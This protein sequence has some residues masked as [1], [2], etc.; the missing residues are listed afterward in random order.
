MKIVFLGTS[1]FAVPSLKKL[2]GTHEIT[3]VITKRDKPQGRRLVS[4]PS[5]VKA[6]AQ[7]LGLP[8]SSVEGLPADKAAESLAA[9]GADIFVVI[10][11]GQIL[12]AKVLSLPGMGSIGLHA[13]L[14]PK[15]RGP[16][17][18]NWAII[19]GETATGVTV[20][21]LNEK[22]D[23][24]AIVSQSRVE[25]LSS[26]NAQT[27]S[28]K[29][30]ATGAE[31]LC[32]SIADMASGKA[33]FT[34]QDARSATVTGKLKKEDGRIDWSRPAQAIHNRIRGLYGWP[35]A[36]SE[37]SGKAVKIW[38]SGLPLAVGAARASSPGTITAIGKDGITVSCGDGSLTIIELQAEGGRR[39]KAS[40]YALGHNV[41]AGDS[42]V[43]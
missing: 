12:P 19:N 1:E 8:V 27:L 17:P 31:L 41:R 25:I 26:D 21:R 28:D 35:G 2:H 13:S 14:L 43:K 5:P 42:F 11:Y 23:E 4:A 16:S 6:A 7:E 32:G 9:Y 15:Y 33:S 20:F 3:A 18:I 39:M 37:L 24:G 34:E 30:A 29:L 38:S 40:E 36:F 10:A 22:M